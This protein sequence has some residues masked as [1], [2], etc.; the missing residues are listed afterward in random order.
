MRG[1]AGD[2]KLLPVRRAFVQDRSAL[3]RGFAE[4][5]G[6]RSEKPTGANLVARKGGRLAPL[7]AAG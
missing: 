5:G 2:H 1:V 4:R 7:G 3:E 6:G